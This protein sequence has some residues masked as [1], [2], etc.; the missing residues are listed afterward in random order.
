VSARGPLRL[1]ARFVV[2]GAG[3]AGSLTAL[4]LRHL[5]H[6]VVLVERGRHPRFAIGESSTPLANLLLEALCDRYALDRVRPLCKMGTWRRAYPGIMRGLKRGFSFAHHAPGQLFDDDEE[7]ARSLLVA[8]SPHDE[9]ADTHW[10]RPDVDAFLADEAARAGAVYLDETALDRFEETG[11]GVRLEGSRYGEA[12]AIR[13]DFLIDAS[14]PRGFLHRALGLPEQPMRWLPPTQTLYAHFTGVGLWEDVNGAAGQ[15][16]YPVDAAALH[17]VFPGGWIWV[18]RFDHGITSAGAALTHP[19]AES[20]RLADGAAAWARLLG[21]LPSVARQFDGSQ[22]VTPFHYAPRLAFRSARI[23][24][25]RWA[26]LPSAAGVVDPLLSTG[27]PLTLL[28]V[29]RLVECLAQHTDDAGLGE[30]LDVYARQ[31][32]RELDATERLVAALYATMADFALFKRLALLYFAAASYSEAVRRLG[33]A[34]RARGFLLCD[35][36][37]FAGAMGACADAAL[38]RPEGAA[39]ERLI[40]RIDRAIAP[41]D[42]AGLGDRARRD[43][44]PVRADDLLEGAARLGATPAEVRT[45]LVRSGFYAAGVAACR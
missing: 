9:I 43:W 18:L 31:T 33:H 14:G 25:R 30:A 7:H 2:V 6:T 12:V 22:A 19:L 24:G 8:A 35:D 16:P 27:F 5:G 20:L 32:A 36:P 41:Y 28:G 10:Y 26:T 13:G 4:A 11:T 39:R 23:A 15:P 42:V 1:D 37:A 29:H 44:Y 34:E 38:E 40:E 45:L 17:H 21:E 3:F